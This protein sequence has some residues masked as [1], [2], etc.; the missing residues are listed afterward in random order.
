MRSA[1]TVGQVRAAEQ[2]LMARL[3][4]GALM[5][6]AAAGLAHAVVDY[7]GWAYGSRV[8]LLVGS[9]DNGGDA[10]FAGALLARRGVQ[11]RA[12]LLKP[13]KAHPD[14]L[15]A[16]RASGGR[17]VTSVSD[18]GTPDLVVDGIVGIGGQGGL[19]E[20]AADL[21]SE[22]A[23]VPVVAVDTPSGIDVDTGRL[24]GPHVRAAV[25][26]TFGTHKV[27]HLVDPAAMACGAVHLV[28]IGLELP[29]PAITSLQEEDVRA[30]LPRPT[31]DAH[32][33]TRGVVGV[34]A[35]SEQYPGAG[36]L[37]TSGASVGMAGM[38]RYV[39]EAA[40]L[41]R[42]RHPEVV[43]G[44]GRVQTWVI[45]SGGGA[46]AEQ[47]L[48]D[49][50]ADEVPVVVDAD[51]LSHVGGPLGVPALLTP[52]AGE[53]A[54]MLDVERE[55]VEAEQLRFA[56]EA[57]ERY[58]AVVLLKGRHTLVASPDGRVSATTVGPAWLATAGAGDVLAGLCGALLAAGLS[59]FDAG[60]VGSWLHGAAAALAGHDGPVTAPD[61]ATALPTLL[62]TLV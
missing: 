19:R 20:D 9:G 47:A 15:A 21:V 2:A 55:E 57:S 58:D 59:P 29:A 25:T 45:G 40:D 17:V 12:L 54:R 36:V 56:R 26:V 62:R 52:H 13:E 50:L 44:K 41:V 60:S 5:Q 39:G 27:G 24:S 30:L 42:A 10:L 34:R 18:G 3:P 49:S 1:H 38:V 11:V 6:R 35:G 61:V 32:K 7:L 51:G 33:Y 46:S 22:L 16:L 14:G 31:P 43:V 8:L 4:E 28:D 37:C 53:L 23:D 48:A